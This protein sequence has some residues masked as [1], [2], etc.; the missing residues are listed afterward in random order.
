M[1]SQ[2]LSD[3][4]CTCCTGSIACTLEASHHH[5]NQ[6]GQLHHY[7]PDKWNLVSIK[8]HEYNISFLKFDNLKDMI[9]AL[10]SH[11]QGNQIDTPAVI[12]QRLNLMY[13]YSDVRSTALTALMLGRG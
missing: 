9:G 2:Q 7:N 3:V 10:G 1:L 6:T 4:H 8:V 5:G 12:T 13:M 11:W